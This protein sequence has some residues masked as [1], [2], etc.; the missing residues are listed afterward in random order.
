[1]PLDVVPVDP[2]AWTHEP[3]GAELVDGRIYGRGTAD[4]KGGIAA[5]IEALATVH[6][7]GAEPPCDVVF[8][9]VA[10]EEV[11]GA[12][13]AGTLLKEGLIEGDACIDPEPT[14]L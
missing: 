7:A 1:G 6:R 10:D 8:H 11:G 13:G 9:L 14:S 4:M 3:F 2:A 12:L 5:A